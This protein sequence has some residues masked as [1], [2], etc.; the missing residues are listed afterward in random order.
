VLA[1]GGL[2]PK[3]DEELSAEVARLP[4]ER[5]VPTSER[6]G[7]TGNE[8]QGMSCLL[9]KSAASPP[10]LNHERIRCG[11]AAGSFQHPPIRK[12]KAISD[13]ERH[14]RLSHP[15]AS[16]LQGVAARRKSSTLAGVA[17]CESQS[18]LNGFVIPGDNVETVG[19]AAR[20]VRAESR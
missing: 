5:D 16:K 18:R 2:L 20:P 14:S 6:S 1:K 3:A 12:G 13:I 19:R 8:N 4:E 7:C 15:K 17:R 11:A 10:E 9:T